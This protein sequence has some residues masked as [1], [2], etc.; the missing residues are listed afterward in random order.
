M[1]PTL[2]RCPEVEEPPEECRR[3]LAEVREFAARNRA[4]IDAEWNALP[5]GRIPK[6]TPELIARA[7]AE[8]KALA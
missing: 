6:P 5:D 2:T 7:D 4:R 1:T 3:A 8:W